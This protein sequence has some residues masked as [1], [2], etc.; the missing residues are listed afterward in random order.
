[1][2]QCNAALNEKLKK[3]K[4]GAKTLKHDSAAH[5]C[6]AYF[7]FQTMLHSW[8]E[9]LLNTLSYENVLVK[10]KGMPLPLHPPHLHPAWR[11][12]VDKVQYQKSLETRKIATLLKLM[13]FTQQWE[14]WKIPFDQRCKQG[15]WCFEWL[16]WLKW[17]EWLFYCA[18][19]ETDFLYHPQKYFFSHHLNKNMRVVGSVNGPC[20]DDLLTARVLIYSSTLTVRLG[21]FG[22]L[23]MSHLL[24]RR[25]GRTSFCHISH[26]PLSLNNISRCKA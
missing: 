18:T 4:S 12:N 20:G 25:K 24:L 19:S 15:I 7:T 2:L 9:I 16:E 26:I 11:M 21:Q 17:L 5:C 3:R 22:S 8:K 14:C 1:M 13:S 6:D 23:V 10:R